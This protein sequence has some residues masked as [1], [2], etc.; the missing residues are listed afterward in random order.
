[1]ITRLA[2]ERWLQRKLIST[3]L[4]TAWG[5]IFLEEF[6]TIVKYKNMN[7]AVSCSFTRTFFSGSKLSVVL[8]FLF[9]L[10]SLS[11]FY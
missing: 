3:M 9:H 2:L 11:S 1:M 6:I 10:I 7:N 8:I 4:T 5:K